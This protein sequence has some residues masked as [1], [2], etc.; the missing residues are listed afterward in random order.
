MPRAFRLIKAKYAVEAFTGDGARRYGGRWNTAGTPVVYASSS[1]ALAI[2]EV[3]VNLE[4]PAELRHYLLAEASFERKLVR[5]LDPAR[6]PAA[7]R[8][9]PAPPEVGALGQEW[10]VAASSAVLDVPSAVVAEER[11]YLLNPRHAHFRQ[12]TLVAP[13]GFAFDPRLSGG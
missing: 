3:L 2:L 6:L 5:R 13:R 4:D 7:W 1:I 11:N 10:L 8:E 12:V 9:N